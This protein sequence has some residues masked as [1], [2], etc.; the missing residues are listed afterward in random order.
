ME[1]QQREKTDA[2]KPVLYSELIDTIF[3]YLNP[4][5]LLLIQKRFYAR[6]HPLLKIRVPTLRNYYED[7]VRKVIQKDMDFVFQQILNENADKW[8]HYKKYMYQSIFFSNYIYFLVHY[9]GIQNAKKCVLCIKNYLSNSGLSQNQHK[10]NIYTNV[11]W[12]TLGLES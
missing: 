12:K 9:C 10:K 5:D 3:S 4:L 11:R 8:L 2:I 1:N 6:F 7:Y